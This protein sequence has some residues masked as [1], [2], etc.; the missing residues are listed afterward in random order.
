MTLWA[1]FLF[2]FKKAS[3][4]FILS[5]GRLEYFEYIDRNKGHCN[6]ELRLVGNKTSIQLITIPVYL[7]ILLM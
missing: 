4:L 5:F 3:N 6:E 1:I 2:L 7:F